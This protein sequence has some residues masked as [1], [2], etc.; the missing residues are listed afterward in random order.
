MN[1]QMLFIGLALALGL[2]AAAPFLT[3]PGLPRQTDAEL[4][5][6]RAA[7]L[8]H[9]LRAG[10]FYPRWAPD[11][12]FGYG[13]PIFNYYAP[14]TYYVANLFGVL[15]G[16]DIVGG[17]KAVFVLGL[18]LA[19]MG[20]YLLGS[21][22]F[23]PKGGVLAAAS[24]VLSPYIVFIDPHARGALAEHFALCLLPLSFYAFGRLMRGVG[25]RW[26]FAGSVLSLAGI[27]FSHNL[28]GLVAA[29]LLLFYWLW[30]ALSGQRKRAGWG[31]LALALA[32]CVIA[33]FWLPFVFE[34]SAIKLEVTGPGHF[35]FREHFLSWTE[36]FAPS[37]VL[38]MRAT[39][40]H[41][42]F[43]LGVAQ[44]TLALLGVIGILRFWL[45][46]RDDETRDVSQASPVS[47][48]T[49]FHFS[50]FV[51]AGAGLIFLMLP[52]SQAIWER[53]P[54]MSYLQFPWRL[55]GV[56]NVMLAVCAA[57]IVALVPS[58]RWCIG[59]ATF[60]LA[61][62][63]VTA[64]PVLYPPLWNPD[65]GGTSPYDIIVWEQNSLALGTTSTGD[66]LPVDAARAPLVPM[67]SLI[68]SYREPGPIDR[69]NRDVLPDD[70]Q[71]EIVSQGPLHDRFS[72][73][74]SQAFILR[75]YTF[76]FPGWRAYVDGE[77]VSIEIAHPEGFITL[78]IPAGEHDV[79][80]RFEDTPPRTAGWIISGVAWV[81]LGLSTLIFGAVG[82][83]S[84][85]DSL[86]IEQ[87][88]CCHSFR[89]LAGV[90]VAFVLLKVFVIDPQDDWF[91]YTSPQGRARA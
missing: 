35:D 18:V 28:I 77:E 33:C 64:L 16:L 79:I 3:R 29:F 30:L 27:V 80:V 37:R 48:N 62:V 73:S 90:L 54:G 57:S 83:S 68:Q 40:P 31:W 75:L 38:D 52:G 5:V 76:Y 22:L 65:F 6:Y 13:Y 63:L 45:R 14:M 86:A 24:F 50:Y 71:L 69:V 23:G 53:I 60:G 70:A 51:L 8:G 89:W 17:A 15:P 49:S 36:L 67:P 20:S 74:T 78:Q 66:F 46:R 87:R 84:A 25:G 61:L 39:A 2:V 21:D 81:M 88:A 1:R 91:R 85:P 43:N 59:I 72:I 11:F 19:S 56:A 10:V 47:R 58:R 42:R 82:H 55:L 12:Y 4:H 34:R 44:W 7:E 26:A 32:A 41:H 9:L